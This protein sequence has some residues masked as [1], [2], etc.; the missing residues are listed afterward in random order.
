MGS[1]GSTGRMEEESTW[2]NINMAIYSM[3]LSLSAANY[4]IHYP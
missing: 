4:D 3:S 1:M 2:S